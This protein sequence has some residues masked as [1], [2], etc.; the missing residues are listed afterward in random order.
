MAGFPYYYTRVKIMDGYEI[1][2][3]EVSAYESVYSVRRR[4]GRELFRSADISEC[5]KYIA[6]ANV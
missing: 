4:G 3:Y 5:E 1:Y 6:A 2:R